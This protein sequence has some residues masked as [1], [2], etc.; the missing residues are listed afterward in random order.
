METI[1]RV[2]LDLLN[3]LVAAAEECADDLACSVDHEYEDRK[4][5][6]S[7]QRKHD[8]DMAPVIELRAAIEAAKGG[9]P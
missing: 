8:R 4:C 1:L 2:P 6:P 3:R 9:L 5:Y 7:I